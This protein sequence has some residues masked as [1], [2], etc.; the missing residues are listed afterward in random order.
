MV[1]T[2]REKFAF[3]VPVLSHAQP[4]MRYQW[5]VLP[6]D[7][8]N[9]PTL[10]QYY[11]YK[12]LT[13]FRSKFPDLI[14]IHYMGDILIAGPTISYMHLQQLTTDLLQYGLHITPKKYKNS[15]LILI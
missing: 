13:P 1:K 11:V 7:K 10:C 15:L 6:Q 5:R 9:S 8:L 2:D 4:I 3:T 14:V 12:A